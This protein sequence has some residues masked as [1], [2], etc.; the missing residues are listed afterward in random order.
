MLNPYHG[1]INVVEIDGADAVTRDGVEWMLYL[2]ADTEEEFLEDGT[3]AR[4]QTPD[5]KYG[6]W[7]VSGGLKRAPMRSVIDFET[8]EARG[9]ALLEAVKSTAP[10][11][12]FRLGD[13]FEYWLLD[14][15]S[16]RP[17]AMI[18][19]SCQFPRESEAP[20][21]WRPGQASHRE[22]CCARLEGTPA[23]TGF[24][25]D[26]THS[27]RLA[28]AVNRAAGDR[29]IAQW[30]QRL[31]DGRGIG[32]LDECLPSSLQQRTLAAKDFPELML[33][34][35]WG[36]PAIRVLA[37]DFLA[38]QAPWLLQLQ[39]L[40]VK[41]RSALECA[42]RRRAG[43]TAA[44]HHLY[45]EIADERQIRAALVEA[46]LRHGTPDR[47]AAADDAEPTFYIEMCDFTV[48]N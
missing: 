34:T 23:T 26:L 40:S 28:R 18:D 36:D 30:F 8:I 48:G 24:S 37:E 14:M 1:V 17:L 10:S 45:P 44:L 15:D 42:A 43:L 22:F 32:V 9:Q 12:P 4:F 5:M 25:M 13:R 39:H 11:A 21:A 20:P 3:V 31:A 27:A 33:A 2:Q 41:T 29:P 46:R 35:D 38:W 16:H 47:P 6:N 19:S 7:S